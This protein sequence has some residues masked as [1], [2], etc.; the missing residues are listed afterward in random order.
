MPGLGQANAAIGAAFGTAAG[1]VAGPVE[2]DDRFF[3][4][5]VIE[6]TPASREAFERQKQEMRARL[7]LQRRQS[8]IDEWL[9][10]LRDRA[11]V[12]DLRQDVFQP[13]S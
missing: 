11:D 1:Q 13:R 10:E 3:L 5:E 4:I 12:V 2:A 6:R 9:Q 7:T 8:A